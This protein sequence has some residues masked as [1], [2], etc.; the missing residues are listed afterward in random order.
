MESNEGKKRRSR[1]YAAS[2]TAAI[3]LLALLAGAP[4]LMAQDAA[5]QQDLSAY[6]ATIQDIFAFI[7]K[8][9]V[10]QVDPK[11]LYEGALK[12]MFESLGDP[13]SLYYQESDV[14]EISDITSGQFGGVGLYI[15]K[16]EADPRYPDRARFIE[17]SSPIEDTP[18]WKAGLMPGDL[19]VEIEGQSTADLTTDDAVLRLRG[20]PNTEVKI[21]VMRGSAIF[22]VSI[23][24]AVIEV[25]TVKKAV[26]PEGYGYLRIIEFTPQTYSRVREALNSFNVAQCKGVIIDLRG[27]PGGLLASVVQISDLFLDQGVIVSTKSRD[28]AE[29]YSYRAKKDLALDK[30]LPLVVLINRWSASASEILAGALKDQKRAYLIGETTYG[31]GSVQHVFSLGK[32]AYKLTMSR[33]YTP[34]DANIDKQGIPPDLEMKLPELAKEQL[35]QL[36]ALYAAGRIKDWAEANPGASKQD[37][38][39][40]VSGLGLKGFE[41]VE[42]YV[43]SLVRDE[44]NR[45]TFAPVYDLDYDPILRKALEILDDQAGFARRMSSIKTVRQLQEE[46]AAAKADKVAAKSTEPSKA[47]KA[48]AASGLPEPSLLPSP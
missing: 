13:Y 39:L 1:A 30:S 42:W 8:N 16:Q 31:K 9:Y 19:I 40:F 20:E 5:G 2:I 4:V 7:H 48:G 6:Y 33:Y 22:P 15:S 27:N 44:L 21:T 3:A 41:G 12:G 36:N 14:T 45:K 23:R 25:P 28:A 43:E 17:I 37:I 32:A 24:R 35:D 29:N 46:A 18:G 11:I 10:D 47:P 34:S 38:A 26:M